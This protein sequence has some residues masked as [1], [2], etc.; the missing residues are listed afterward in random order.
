MTRRRFFVLSAAAAFLGAARAVAA[1]R[2]RA[3]RERLFPGRVRP[4]DE[5]GVRTPARWL[6]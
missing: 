6:G 3:A 4:L 1:D 2:V 5:A